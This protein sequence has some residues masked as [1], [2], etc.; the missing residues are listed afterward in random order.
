MKCSE[1]YIGH[2]KSYLCERVE[3]HTGHH[4]M[5]QPD[6]WVASWSFTRMPPAFE[7]PVWSWTLPNTPAV[8]MTNPD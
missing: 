6:G 8:A 4:E 1:A 3:G 2:G 5:T 7:Y